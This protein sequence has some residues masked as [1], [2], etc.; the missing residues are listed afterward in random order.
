MDVADDIDKVV[1]AP[2]P[3]TLLKEE[4]GEPVAALSGVKSS[5]A[6][7][8]VF[9][10]VLLAASA[11]CVPRILAG[12]SQGDAARA[13]EQ[14]VQIAGPREQPPEILREQRALVEDLDE[15]GRALKS[16]LENPEGE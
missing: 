14:P 4:P 1:G 9:L 5:P 11:W 15:Q 10:G 13:S 12:I 8:V 2:P 3:P 16:A 6:L 7:W